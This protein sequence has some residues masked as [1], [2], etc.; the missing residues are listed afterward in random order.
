MPP[1]QLH[2]GANPRDRYS[3]RFAWAMQP[4]VARHVERVSYCTV[5]FSPVQDQVDCSRM[6]VMG[7]EPWTQ[8]GGEV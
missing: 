6:L 5:P 4:L 3:A 2:P 1:W 7:G 8:H